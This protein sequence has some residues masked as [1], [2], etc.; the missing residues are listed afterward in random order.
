MILDIKE[1]QRT[2]VVRL[3]GFLS[4]QE[5]AMIKALKHEIPYEEMITFG[6]QIGL[7]EDEEVNI[8]PVDN[9]KSTAVEQAIIEGNDEALIG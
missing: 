9:Q 7:V 4:L 2:K 8:V 1:A 3:P 5:D 6:S